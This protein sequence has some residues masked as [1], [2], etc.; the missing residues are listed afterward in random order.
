M[1]TI[2]NNWLYVK[3]TITKIIRLQILSECRKECWG[4]LNFETSSDKDTE[5]ESNFKAVEISLRLWR[6]VKFFSHL[7]RHNE[8]VI[9]IILSKIGRGW[10][11]KRMQICHLKG[12]ASDGSWVYSSSF[13]FF[14][15][16]SELGHYC[17]RIRNVPWES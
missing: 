13:V 6:E 14:T 5:L 11:N 12:T 3:Y 7:I 8:V 15:E 17:T 16:F 1:I 4:N 2:L 9:N 10:S